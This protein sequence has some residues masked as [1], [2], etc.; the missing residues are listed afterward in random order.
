M[1]YPFCAADGMVTAVTNED[2]EDN[3]RGPAAPPRQAQ[4]GDAAPGGPQQPPAAPA[5]EGTVIPPVYTERLSRTPPRRRTAADGYKR[6]PLILPVPQGLP[7]LPERECLCCAH[8]GKVVAS[9][10]THT[11][12]TTCQRNGCKGV[13][14]DCGMI[15]PRVLR[16]LFRWIGEQGTFLLQRS[17]TM[18]V[19]NHSVLAQY[20]F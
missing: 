1:M 17:G 13:D 2:M 10:C 6:V 14:G 20:S 8:C 4:P 11:H 5:D 3:A 15:F 12:S 9:A 18:Q 16:E 19:G 7:P